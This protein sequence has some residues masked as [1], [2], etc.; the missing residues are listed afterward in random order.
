VVW[1]CRRRDVGE[2]RI[3]IAQ[4]LELDQLVPVEQFARELER[5]HGVVGGV[6]AGGV[7]QQGKF[8]RG[9]V[10]EQRR[11]VRILAD[12][13]AA[14]R[15]GDDLRARCHDRRPRRGE[16]LVL[17]GTDEEARTASGPGNDQRVVMGKGD[18]FGGSVHLRYLTA[19]DGGDHFDSIT[20]ADH[21]FGVPAAWDDLTI[22][23]YR[24][25]LAL[26]RQ[27]ADEIGHPGRRRPA[28]VRC[29]IERNRDHRR[30]SLYRARDYHSGWRV[31]A[32]TQRWR[33]RTRPINA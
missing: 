6:A 14:N 30:L 27:R 3:R 17:A 11:L 16:V 28:D 31:Q 23:F 25:A 24:D 29:A 32:R 33:G 5:T 7:G 9:Q 20:G 1:A 4:D 18:F 22:L 12:V 8:R 2:Q 10:V 15:D 26:E 19:A 13:R 21:G